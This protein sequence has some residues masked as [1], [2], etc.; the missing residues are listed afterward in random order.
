MYVFHKYSIVANHLVPTLRWQ[1]PNEYIHSVL[2]MHRHTSNESTHYVQ[3]YTD[4]YRVVLAGMV[5]I[6]VMLAICNYKY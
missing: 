2:S 3:C 6:H 5:I 4:D 1:T